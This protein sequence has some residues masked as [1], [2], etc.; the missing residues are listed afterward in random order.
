MGVIPVPRHWDPENL[1]V[2]YTTFS[3]KSWIPVGFVASLLMKG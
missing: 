1:I 3:I 2:Y